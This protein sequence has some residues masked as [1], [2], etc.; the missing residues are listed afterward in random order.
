MIRTLSIVA[1]AFA[2][3]LAGCAA[4]ETPQ[5]TTTPSTTTPATTTPVV[6]TPAPGGDNETPDG[7]GPPPIRT[8]CLERHENTTS[9]RL[10][11]PELVFN[12]EEPSGD[13][14]CYSFRGPANA[15]SGWNVFTLNGAN[16]FHIMPMFY[17]GNRTLDDA[18]QAL[19]GD[20]PPEWATPAGAV[21]GVTRGENG[22][23][24]LDL[25]PGNYFYF[26]P[27]HGHMF[28]GMMGILNVTQADEE[29]EPPTAD[30]R[31][32][33]VD[34]NF[35][36][37]GELGAQTKV[38]EVVNVGSEPHEAPLFRLHGNA[39]VMDFLH[40]VEDPN[41]TGPPPGAVMGGVNVI[42]PGQTAYIL[43]DLEAGARYGMACFAESESHGGAAHL[44]LGM[45][46]E[47]TA[48][49]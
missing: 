19:A 16:E 44:E 15:T 8:E 39:T 10:G 3:A 47:F 21:G 23:V 34:Y 28:Q 4:D 5:T 12:I 36:L 35:T 9:T 31:I 48:D 38:I 27:I 20:G 14:G 41:A 13:D 30:A 2:V 33:L 7:E 17:I 46:K 25:E 26:C 32:E 6:T 29:A 45:V 49:A 22:S 1:L 11:M 40:A 43:V 37:P 42:A 24:A 18:L